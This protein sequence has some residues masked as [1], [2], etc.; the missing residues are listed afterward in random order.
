VAVEKRDRSGS[1][2]LY[3]NQDM[4]ELDLYST[5]GTVYCLCDS[6]NYLIKD[7]DVAKTFKRVFDFLYPGGLFIFDF[8]TDHKY[9]NVIGT[10]TIA[11]DRDDV[12]FIWENSYDAES[13]INEYNLTIFIKNSYFS[14]FKDEPEEEL[15]TFESDDNFFEDLY[16]KHSETHLQ[17]GYSFTDMT[18]FVEE[19]GFIL[20]DAFDLDM[21]KRREPGDIS[22]RIFI[23]AKKNMN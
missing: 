10:R 3:L 5:V 22:E 11:E 17:R 18:A 13:G 7:E 12:S 1:E 20:V 16:R 2:I 8:N 21:E 15:N 23:V 4:R 14:D 6:I 9:R 19:A